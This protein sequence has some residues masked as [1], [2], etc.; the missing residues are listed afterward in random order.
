MYVVINNINYLSQYNIIQYKMS[1]KYYN[2][3]YKNSNSSYS[4]NA[5]TSNMKNKKT[6][7]VS[8]IWEKSDN[9]NDNSKIY[10]SF[11]MNTKHIDK[12]QN[13][14]VKE[15]SSESISSNSDYDS[16]SSASRSSRSKKSKD[17]SGIN[18]NNN[19][20]GKNSIPMTHNP[21]FYLKKKKYR[22]NE[23]VDDDIE[24]NCII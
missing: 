23:K 1:K 7:G 4:N 11:F 10:N 14:D 13:F 8:P 12:N 16:Y 15:S 22:E 9:E 2:Q 5:S 24:H 21:D 20:L 19:N 3:N 6:G 17:S 18:K